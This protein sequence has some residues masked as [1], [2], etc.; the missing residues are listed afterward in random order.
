M[1]KAL[2]LLGGAALAI[3]AMASHSATTSAAPVEY[4]NLGI[5][6]AAVGAHTIVTYQGL[7]NGTIVTNQFAGSGVTHTDGND[8]AID[9]GAFVDGEGVVGGGNVLIALSFSGLIDHIGVEYP[10]AV[11]FRLY[12]GLSLVYT[13]SQFGGS[14]SGFFAGVSGVSFDSAEIFDWFAGDVFVDNLHFGSAAV[15]E[16]ATLALL[17]LGLAGLGIARRRKAA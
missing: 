16:P 8:V 12:S 7:T 9:N 17:G 10:G 2:K 3:A 11:Q 5:Y 4:T 14:G 13:S 6:N 1:M 15:P